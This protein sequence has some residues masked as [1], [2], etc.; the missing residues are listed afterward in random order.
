MS[1]RQQSRLLDPNWSY[2]GKATL[3]EFGA[4]EWQILKA[5]RAPYMAEQHANQVLRLLA[6]SKDDPTFGYQVNNFRHCIQSATMALADGRPEDYVVA[7]LLHDI[8]FIAC[9][10]THGAFSARLLAPFVGDDL[11]WMLERHQY[12]QAI[13]FHDHPDVDRFAREK[14]RGHPHFAMTAEFVAKYDQNTID[15]GIRELPIEAFEP[16]V[17]HVFARPPRA[18][19]LP[20]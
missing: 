2:V 10:P 9:T 18:I 17:K 11:V 15:P 13:H 6:A 5:Q 12:F 19:P 7:A 16:M 3:D 8:G 14:W 1:D 4:A 20:D